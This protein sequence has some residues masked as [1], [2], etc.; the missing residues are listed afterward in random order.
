MAKDACT[1]V[2]YWMGLTIPR[3]YKWIAAHNRNLEELERE[4]KK[5][6]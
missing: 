3:L 1:P 6:G 5:K 4:R 2:S